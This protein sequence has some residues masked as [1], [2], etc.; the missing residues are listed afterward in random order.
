MNKQK[1]AK[2]ILKLKSFNEKITKFLD[3]FFRVGC[4]I[5]E[6]AY[7]LFF[8][9]GLG[10]Y[11]FLS[12]SELGVRIA[13]SGALIIVVISVMTLLYNSIIGWAEKNK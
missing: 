11:A 9:F 4:I 1:I 12:D 8:L 5:I 13:C 10:Y 2:K 3:T 7:C 6:G